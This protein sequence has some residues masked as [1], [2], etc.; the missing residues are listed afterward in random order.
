MIVQEI[1]RKS[2]CSIQVHEEELRWNIRY[3]K[4]HNKCHCNFVVFLQNQI[5]EDT[6][7]IKCSHSIEGKPTAH[8]LDIHTD[9]SYLHFSNHNVYWL[10][11]VFVHWPFQWFASYKPHIYRCLLRRFLVLCFK[12]RLS[13]LVS[14]I[15]LQRQLTGS[16]ADAR[17]QID[18]LMMEEVKQVSHHW[19][20]L[21][22]SV[23]SCQIC[24][25]QWLDGQWLQCYMEHTTILLMWEA[26]N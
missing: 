25:G 23:P 11:F 13:E 14:Q 9:Q 8:V 18:P 12:G 19:I 20:C 3:Y 2:G 5:R 21:L 16:R 6:N 24:D 10:L 22:T 26:T 17:Y 1:C 15:R 7:W 4:D